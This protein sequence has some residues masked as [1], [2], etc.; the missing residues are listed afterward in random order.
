MPLDPVFGRQ[1]VTRQVYGQSAQTESYTSD[2]AHF[3]T[4]VPDGQGGS[5]G[6]TSSDRF[7]SDDTVHRYRYDAWGRLTEV[8]RKADSKVIRRHHYDAEGRRVKTVD[9]AGAGAVTTRLLWWGEGLAASYEE[10]GSQANIRSYGYTGGPDG[11]AFVVVEQAGPANGSYELARDFQG[12]VLALIDRASG[13]LAE[14]Y[15]YTPF[16]AVT[17]LESNTATGNDRFFLGRPYDAVTGLHD[18]RARWYDAASG[19]FLSPDPLGAI[20]SWNLYQYGLAAP[21]TWMDP[22]GL[23]QEPGGGSYWLTIGLDLGDGY[24]DLARGAS[25][26]WRDFTEVQEVDGKL[27]W[28]DGRLLSEAEA[29]LADEALARSAGEAIR[30]VARGLRLFAQYWIAA[31]RDYIEEELGTPCAVITG[32]NPLNGRELVFGER[33]RG[34]I[35]MLSHVSGGGRAARAVGKRAD[36]GFGATGGRLHG[37]RLWGR[38]DTLD[39]HFRRHGADFGARNADEYAKQASDFFRQ[40]Q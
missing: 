2:P 35:S 28:A 39:D 3:Y 36:N 8:E 19:A 31:V 27:N 37:R 7:L 26:E 23:S 9:T 21:A 32:T 25:G 22:S 12:S 40:S 17:V 29:K 38:P 18:L 4:S 5:Q 11:E 10:G 20:D 16:G 33:L 15:G 13:T 1:T 30:Y 34:G 6:R 24:R 14:R